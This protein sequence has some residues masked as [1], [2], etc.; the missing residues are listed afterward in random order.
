M[1]SATARCQKI[2]LRIV[3]LPEQLAELVVVPVALRERLL[4]DRRVR[5]DADD[6]VLLDQLR[7]RA[8]AEPLAR[9][10]VD[11]DALPVLRQLMQT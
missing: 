2:S 4:E 10:R 8:V 7:E 6:G 3:L 9:E 11:P 1:T 5:G